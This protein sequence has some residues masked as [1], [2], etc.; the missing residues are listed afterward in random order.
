M[1]FFFFSFLLTNLFLLQ[2]QCEPVGENF[3]AHQWWGI[4][5]FIN[6]IYFDGVW[7]CT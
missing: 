3:P 2:T 1:A 6:E 5:F 7:Y 4:I